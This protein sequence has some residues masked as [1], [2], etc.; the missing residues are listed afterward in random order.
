MEALGAFVEGL[1]AL[2]E[3]L[4]PRG[5]RKR[6]GRAVMKVDL[7][8]KSGKLLIWNAGRESAVDVD[9]VEAVTGLRGC[10]GKTMDIASRSRPAWHLPASEMKPD[11]ELYLD[12]LIPWEES[13]PPLQITL[14]WR[15]KVTGVR[16]R[17]EFRLNWP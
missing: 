3:I 15:E 2:F 4:A 5:D 11:Q 13:G 12:V 9:V 14:A 6:P 10:Q 7:L 16:R 17:R 1:E 8:R